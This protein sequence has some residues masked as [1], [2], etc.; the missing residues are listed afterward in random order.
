LRV[1][2]RLSR[3]IS[4]SSLLSDMRQAADAQEVHELIAAREA[5][6]D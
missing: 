5:D 6:L 2:A 4:D 1:L 3:L